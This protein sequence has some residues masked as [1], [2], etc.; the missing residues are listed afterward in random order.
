MA[1]SGPWVPHHPPSWVLQPRQSLPLA[2]PSPPAVPA[3]C[4]LCPAHAMPLPDRSFLSSPLPVTLIPSS[5]C[6]EPAPLQAALRVQQARGVTVL[7]SPDAPR[8]RFPWTWLGQRPDPVAGHEAPAAHRPDVG[9]GRLQDP[10][11]PVRPGLASRPRKQTAEQGVTSHVLAGSTFPTGLGRAARAKAQGGGG[12]ARDFEKPC[13]GKE[14][15]VTRATSQRAQNNHSTACARLAASTAPAAAIPL[16]GGGTQQQ[17]H[18]PWGALLPAGAGRCSR[19]SP[20]RLPWQSPMCRPGEEPQQTEAQPQGT[21]SPALPGT[22]LLSTLLDWPNRSQRFTAAQSLRAEFTLEGS[23]HG[24]K[25]TQRQPGALPRSPHSPSE[26]VAAG[27]QGTKTG[28]KKSLLFCDPQ[29]VISILLP[30]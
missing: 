27:M 7:P 13:E 30:Y 26:I 2:S 19:T 8:C 16:G 10:S 29:D 6:R 28:G 25:R 4:L 20:P 24:G 21:P 1:Q 22:H 11:Q 9:P 5:P 18:D 3:A 23:T 15:S 14:A 12:A 17:W